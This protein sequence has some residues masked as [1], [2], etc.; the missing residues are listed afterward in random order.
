MTIFHFSSHKYQPKSFDLRFASRHANLCPLCLTR[1][2]SSL[3]RKYRMYRK[4]L[5]LVGF[6]ATSGLACGPA[7]ALAQQA[8]PVE[9]RFDKSVA[10]IAMRDGVK[11]H[12]SV[13]VPKDVKGPLPFILLRTYT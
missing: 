7:T 2:T 13:Y 10:M 11:L 1:F 5:F 12:T 8:L 4:A 9:K 6:V 3:N